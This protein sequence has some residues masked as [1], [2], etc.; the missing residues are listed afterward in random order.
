MPGACMYV[1]WLHVTGALRSE[2]EA[3][4]Y[5]C[6]SCLFVCAK[7]LTLAVPVCCVQPSVCLLE[8]RGVSVVRSVLIDGFHVSA[9][10]ACV[11]NI[12]SH[13]V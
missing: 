2:W 7:P 10:C 6:V 8:Q 9:V 11:R 1:C 4:R 5:Q 13:V 12:E 3:R